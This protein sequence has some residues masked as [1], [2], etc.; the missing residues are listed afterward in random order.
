M[1]INKIRKITKNHKSSTQKRLITD[2]KKLCNFENY[3]NL[4]PAKKKIRLEKAASMY[5]SMDVVKNRDIR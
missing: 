5:E 2:R 4:E 1:S 3:A